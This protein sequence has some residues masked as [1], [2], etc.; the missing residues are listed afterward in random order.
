MTRVPE[1]IPLRQR[2]IQQNRGRKSAK[3]EGADSSLL[4][5]GV[6]ARQKAPTHE[7]QTGYRHEQRGHPVGIAPNR[8]G[9]NKMGLGVGVLGSNGTESTLK[10]Q[11]REP[12]N[13]YFT[14]KR[15]EA[16]EK[17]SRLAG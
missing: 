15:S 1:G 2:P 13:R 16:I 17:S 6:E 11:G 5:R 7:R 10:D 9:A 14:K 8:L 12:T 3:N 4:K